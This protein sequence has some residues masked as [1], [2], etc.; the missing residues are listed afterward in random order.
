MNALASGAMRRPPC[1]LACTL[2]PALAALSLLAAVAC[3]D[4]PP[5]RG[6]DGKAPPVV[7]G[8]RAHAASSSAAP[9]VSVVAAPSASASTPAASAQASA[10]VAI[11]LAKHP[12]LIDTGGKPLPQTD[13][14]PS[15]DS[16]AFQRRLELLWK[17]IVQDD[18]SIA[19][20]VF[21][22]RVAYAQVKDIKNPEADWKSRLLRAFE[23]NIH[24]YHREL[25]DAPQAAR[26]VR[27]EV[28]EKRVKLMERGKEGNKLPYHRVTRSQIHFVD[29][30]GKERKL[31]LTSLI[32]WRGEW[33]VV[34]LHGFK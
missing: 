31:E 5:P 16:P 11:D 3:G 15:V 34:H 7:S 30:A 8:E 2:V 9:A 26:L 28:D 20:D 1:S 33:F 21:F 23:R 18:P 24:E 6:T 17:A 27:L 29:G 22:P 25:G 14:R 13:D 32:A 10:P 4:A 12:E 19:S